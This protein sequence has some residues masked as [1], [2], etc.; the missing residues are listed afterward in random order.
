VWCLSPIL[1]PKSLTA[2]V[3]LCFAFWFEVNRQVSSPNLSLFHR[4]TCFRVL[5]GV[6][7]CRSGDIFAFLLVFVVLS[8]SVRDLAVTSTFSRLF[9]PMLHGLHAMR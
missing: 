9:L 8:I 3:D 5:T 4:S 1:I 7:I 6:F 2:G